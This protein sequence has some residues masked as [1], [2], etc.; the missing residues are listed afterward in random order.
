MRVPR[1]SQEEQ[2]KAK[3]ALGRCQRALTPSRVSVSSRSRTRVRRAAG[4]Q[5]ST[6]ARRTSRSSLEPKTCSSRRR[7][8]FHP[9]PHPCPQ[10]SQ[11]SRLRETGH[12]IIKSDPCL[13]LALAQC[14]RRKEKPVSLSK[15]DTCLET[16][17]LLVFVFGRCY[18]E[19]QPSIV[20][21][22][23]SIHE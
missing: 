18:C 21:A 23:Q 10:M 19:R 13:F 20:H 9:L 2:S 1:A 4:Q 15:S 11:T 7:R 22:R 5:S 16:P 17:L 3:K 8:S 12:S 14:P 6:G